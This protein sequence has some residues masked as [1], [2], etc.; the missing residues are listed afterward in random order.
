MTDSSEAQHTPR[1]RPTGR[2]W[3]DAQRRVADRNDEA[4][5]AGKA[6]RTAREKRER[7]ARDRAERNGVYR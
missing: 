5:K 7:E 1:E 3:V 6:E 4:Q 2:A